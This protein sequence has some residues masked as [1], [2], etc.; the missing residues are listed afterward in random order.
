VNKRILP[1]KIT[2]SRFSG[3]H[4]GVMI[5]LRD[6]TSGTVALRAEMTIEE[7]GYAITACAARPCT[8]EWFDA[9]IGKRCEQKSEALP[10]PDWSM[11]KPESAAQAEALLAPYEVDGWKGR[12]SDLFNHHNWTKDN[13]VRVS[14]FRYVDAAGTGGEKR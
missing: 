7:F 1:G 11:T 10:R 5:E 12:T 6:E 3:S 8:V 2:I 9:P 4:E 14:F 13:R